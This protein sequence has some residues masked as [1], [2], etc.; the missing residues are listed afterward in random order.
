MISSGLNVGNAVLVGIGEA[1]IVAVGLGVFVSLGKVIVGDGWIYSIVLVADV[2]PST[3]ESM[4]P[5]PD[6]NRNNISNTIFLYVLN[7]I[8]I[9]SLLLYKAAKFMGLFQGKSIP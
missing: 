8:L 3:P 2:I 1:V 4:V 9:L 7:F 6:I 5:Q